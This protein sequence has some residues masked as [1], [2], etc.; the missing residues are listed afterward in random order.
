VTPRTRPLAPCWLCWRRSAS[1]SGSSACWRWTRS[2]PWTRP[3]RA[4]A[5]V[6]AG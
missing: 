4:C 1:S 6:R 5:R 2:W 3:P